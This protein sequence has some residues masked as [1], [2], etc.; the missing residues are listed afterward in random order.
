MLNRLPTSCVPEATAY[1]KLKLLHIHHNT[2]AQGATTMQRQLPPI[3][4]DIRQ[5]IGPRPETRE[6][7]PYINPIMR[8]P[9]RPP[10]LDD[11]KMRDSRPN[12]ITDPNIDFEENSPH[13]EGIIFRNI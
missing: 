5:P 11:N 4:V 10:D 13:Q 9:P 12:L 7:P 8:P 1:N 3:E 2:Q 6:T